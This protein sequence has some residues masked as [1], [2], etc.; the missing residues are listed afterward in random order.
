M[1]KLLT[2]TMAL[3]LAAG[4]AGCGSNNNTPSTTA[5]TTGT[6]GAV[7]GVSN[8][9]GPK[10]LVEATSREVQT[11]DYVVTA[12]ATDHELNANFVD[13][14]LERDP[15]GNLVGALAE[16]WT[17]NED[18]SVWTFNI[19]KGVKWVT[20]TGEEYA[21]LTAQD[22][23]DGLRH[24]A[25]FDSATAWLLQGVVE[26]YLEYCESDKSDEAWANVGVKAV[27]DYTLE[28]TLAAPTP[29]FDSMTTYAVLYPVNRTFLESK[30][31]G[32]KLGAPD[33]ATC[34]YGTA[35]PDSI[36]YNGG[37]LL[38]VYDVKSQTVL[39][40]NQSYWDAEHVYLDTV[41][42]IYDDGSDPYSVMKGFE[43]GTYSAAALNPGWEDYAAYAEKYADYAVAAE[44]NASAFGVVFNYNRQVYNY[45]GHADEA[46]KENTRKAILNEDFRKAL[47][48]A[49]DKQ[50]YLEIA[51]PTDVA[52]A[53]LRNINNYPEV[54]K[55]S[56]GTSYGD[57]VEKVYNETTGETRD[58]S[59]GVDAFYAP[60]EVQG[61]LDAAVE[62]G[63]SLPV[64]LD[65]MVIKTS[66]KL[67]KQ[68]Q[69]MK[70]SVETNTNGQIIINLIM[71][72]ED[73]VQN[74]CYYNTDPYADDY[75][76]ST[77]TGWSPD[78][79]DP[80]SYVDV[81]SPTTG[82]YMTSIGLG[83]IDK[84]GNV[85]DE[86]I[87]EQIGLM[88]YEEL[89]RAADAITD[90]LDARY[91]A[92]AKADSYLIEHAIFVPTSQQ[93]RSLGVKKEVPFTRPDSHTGI[94]EYKYKFLQLQDDIVTVEQ[95]EATREARNARL[96]G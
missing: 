10:D 35:N 1:K 91:E 36:L 94:S 41:T 78:Y 58:L 16:S 52:K 85:V 93:T 96:A 67:V 68:S 45:T 73:T 86:A 43:E 82:Y 54:V 17:S 81:Y 19:R 20:N 80:K 75:D 55:M 30:G 27:D 42:R 57:L 65:M 59:D 2:S 71:E 48:A 60:D 6:T 47:R 5:G 87:K 92:F 8:Y 24:G 40:K 79:N 89:Y 21:E 88:E 38:S 70:N 12:L 74:I 22:F 37:F 62:A 4:V 66:D 14:L 53:T 84:D 31:V 26:G 11:L 50:A 28:Y 51:A 90:D 29:Y 9:T 25:D 33:K 15:D 32:C 34:E 61:Y 13:G 49:Y 23:V 72:D 76:I 64:T 95:Y 44:P 83:T 7:D 63:V 18:K 46:D 69:S 56:D 39:T 77:F 3:L